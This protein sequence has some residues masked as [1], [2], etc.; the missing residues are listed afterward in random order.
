METQPIDQKDIFNTARKIA[1]LTARQDYL[2]L[3]CGNDQDLLARVKRMIEM[4]EQEQSFLESSPVLSETSSIPDAVS[5]QAGD[6]IGPYKLLQ[7]IGEGGMGIVYLAEQ[8]EPVKRRVAIKIIK[9]GMD[10]RQVIARFEAERQALAMMNHPNIAKVLDAGAT[11]SGRPYFVMELVNGVPITEYCD[12]QKLSTRQRLSLFVAVCQAVHHAHQKGVIHRDIKPSNILVT[13]YDGVPVPKVIDFGISK[14]TNQRLTEKTL[15]THFGQLIGTPIYMSPEQAEMSGLDTDTRSDIYSMGV[16]LYELLTGKTPF[17]RERLLDAG[18][19]EMQRII[20]EEDPPRPSARITTLNEEI[21]SIA[22]NRSSDSRRLPNLVRG[23]LDWIAMKALEKDRQRRYASAASFA[24]D[25]EHY[26]KD[27]P[28][29]ACPPSSIYLLGKFA[30]RNRRSLA[31]WG[32]GV[33]ALLLFALGLLKYQEQVRELWQLRKEQGRLTIHSPSEL[34]AVF[35]PNQ[36]ERNMDWSWRMY[37]PPGKEVVF[38]FANQMIPANGL[39]DRDQTYIWRNAFGSEVIGSEKNGS[40]VR[41]RLINDGTDA[42]SWKIQLSQGSFKI[43]W[44]VQK[45]TSLDRWGS[46]E[47]AGAQ[48]DHSV[49]TRGFGESLVLVRQRFSVAEQTLDGSTSE[50]LPVDKPLDGFLVWLEL[51]DKE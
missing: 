41:V 26:L 31:I 49:V 20:A 21:D 35:L 39:P 44:P 9:P 27:E 13:L 25:I 40:L 5:E 4:H 38:C 14:A 10:S 24:E 37:A 7:Q 33:P 8:R 30:R 16:L 45:D 12:E 43:S 42:N 46:T 47:V 19:A 15:F 3:A 18:Y 32:L 6:S 22:G 23:E 29:S 36:S 1:D 2:E 51:K 17:D 28:V 48:N 34:N 50:Y 11:S